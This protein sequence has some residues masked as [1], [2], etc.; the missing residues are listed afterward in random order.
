MRIA[1]LCKRRYMGKDV[2]LDRY[3]RLYELPYQLARKGHTVHCFC[4]GYQGQADSM[5]QHEAAPGELVWRARSLGAARLPRLVGYPR[6]LLARLRAFAPDVVYGASD[7]PHA[8]LTA[9]LARKLKKPYA[10]DLYD[11]FEGFGQARLP[12]FK[13][14]LR[15]ATRRAN[16]VT[17]TSEA[18]RELVVHQYAARGRV[19]AMP[20]T[21]DLALFRPRNRNAC[22][23]RLG[24]PEDALLIGTAG[25][26]YSDKG[27]GALYAAWSKLAARHPRAHLVL[28]GPSDS[29]LPPPCGERVHYLGMLSHADTAELF[30]A[31]DLGVIYLRDTPFG[32]YCFPQK[33]YEMLACE[34]PVVAA[35]VGAMVPLLGDIPN[36]LYCPDDPADLVRAIDWQLEH[37]RLLEQPIEDWA[38]LVARLEPQ[39]CAVAGVTPV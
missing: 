10:I 32:R 38:T 39:L 16:L 4:L 31:L 35:A 34:L 2:I 36:S 27:V 33:A 17:T 1:F 29:A 9:W 14:M 3:A 23:Q 19:L 12:G 28:A 15:E 21:V 22:R 5:E 7:I 18:L 8:G 13:R 24:L 26:L 6:W 25:G 30:G 20:S 37:A 11:N